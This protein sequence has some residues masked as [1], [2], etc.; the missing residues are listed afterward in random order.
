MGVARLYT[1]SVAQTPEAIGPGNPG[2]ARR[3]Q[4]CSPPYTLGALG[5]DYVQL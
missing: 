3:R 5:L 4:K 1:G 2:P